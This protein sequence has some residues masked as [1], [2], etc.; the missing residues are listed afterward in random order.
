MARPKPVPD[1]LVVKLGVKMRDCVCSG[2]PSPLSVT[3]TVIVLAV[4]LLI[5]AN[6]TL[7]LVSTL[8]PRHSAAGW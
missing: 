4:Q 3:L 8:L 2:I 7:I 5:H 6:N 1:V